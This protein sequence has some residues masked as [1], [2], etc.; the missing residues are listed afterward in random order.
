ME[1]DN[2]DITAMVKKNGYKFIHNRRRDRDKDRGGG[3]GVM[4][5]SGIVHK[6]L[7]CKSFSSFEHSM[8]SIK[9]VNNTKL[10]LI[11]IY[12]LQF[13]STPVF[14]KEFTENVPGNV[15]CITGMFR[16]IR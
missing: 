4:M 12:R 14:M 11:T 8:I 1:A 5:K 9:L 13:I 15:E 7:P 16:I 10:V 3:V 2:N 6:H